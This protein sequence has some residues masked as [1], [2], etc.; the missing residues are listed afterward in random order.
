MKNIYD[1]ATNVANV[2]LVLHGPAGSGKTTLACQFPG[3]YIADLDK[4]LGGPLR[5]LNDNKRQFPVGYDIISEKDDGSPIAMPFRYQR[6]T[7][8]LQKAAADPTVE[9]ILIDSLTNFADILIAETLRIQG[10]A[11]MSKQEWGFFFSYGKA[12]LTKMADINKHIIFNAHEKMVKTESGA[13]IRNEIYFPGQLSSIMASLVTDVWHTEVKPDFSGKHKF[14]VKTMPD[15]LTNLKNS[16]GL[17][18]EFEF[19]WAQVADRLKALK[20]PI[21]R[22]VTN[23]D[24]SMQNTIKVVETFVVNAANK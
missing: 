19:T 2:R 17:P 13:V 6:L 21:P 1:Y 23:A 16:L 22:P 15:A 14:M 18:S 12:F 8:C 4:N 7:E 11:V 5:W 9:T 10:K 3:V 24:A 20:N